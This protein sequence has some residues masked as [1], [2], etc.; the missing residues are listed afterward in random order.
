M[1]RGSDE[2]AALLRRP[3]SII[4]T[5]DWMQ[6]ERARELAHHAAEGA[7]ILLVRAATAEQLS[8]SAG[9]LL[10][11]GRHKLQ[12]HVFARPANR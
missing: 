6:E 4:G 3:G 1:V 12:T 10:R 2:M 8:T 7:V 5:L 11:H 9:V